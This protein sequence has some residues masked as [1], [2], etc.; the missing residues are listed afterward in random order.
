LYRGNLNRG[1]KCGFNPSNIS[2]SKFNNK[3]RYRVNSN[4][5]QTFRV[6]KHSCRYGGSYLVLHTHKT[7]YQT[8]S[9]NNNHSN[10]NIENNYSNSL[11]NNNLKSSVYQG[12]IPFRYD[13]NYK[14]K[15]ISV[16]FSIYH[17][18]ED[19]I[20]VFE[21]VLQVGNVYTMFVRVRFNINMFCMLGKQSGFMYN[22]SEDLLNICVLI[23]DRLNHYMND[24]QLLFED[25]SY[26]E[27]TFRLKDKVLLSE[28][29]SLSET[30]KQN[31]INYLSEK[32]IT[33]DNKL[34]SIP[35]SINENYLG[36]PLSVDIDKGFITNI[37]LIVD[38]KEVNFL[39][40]KKKKCL[41]W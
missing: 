3:V 16:T 19:W 32:D 9:P 36:N 26:I 23:E 7:H 41:S 31:N 37:K 22:K 13:D 10:N 14:N 35:I 12:N 18:R 33:S 1:N 40:L 2:L 27:V 24:Y 11:D 29:V 4:N 39:D 34:L 21:K 15:K 38:K 20:R 28:F 30:A 25:I 8:S 6:S 17:Y 5:I